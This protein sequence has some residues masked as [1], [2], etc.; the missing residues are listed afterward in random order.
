[1]PGYLDIDAVVAAAQRARR[2]RQSTPA[3]ASCPSGPGSPAAVEAA[4]LVLVGPSADG[5][6]RRWVARTR[7]ARSRSP[8]GF[9][10]CLT[11]TTTRRFPVLVKAAAGGGGKGMRIVRRAEEYA[12]AVAAAKREAKAAFGDDTMLVEKY[13]EHGRHIEVQVLGR[14][15][16]ERGAPLRAG[17]LHPAAAPEGARG[18]AGADHQRRAPRG[19]HRRGGRPGRARRLHQRRHRRVPARHEPAPARRLLPGDEHPAPGRAPGDRARRPG[20]GRALDLVELQLRVAAGEPLP[21][22]Q[23]DVTRRRARDRGPGL[24]RGPVRRLPPAGRARRPRAL[25][26]A[27]HAWTTRW[28]AGRRSA[29]PTTRCSARSSPTGPT[30]RPRAGRWS[31]PSTTPRSWV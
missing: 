16:R 30:A 7:P 20:P 10:S 5:D 28:R 9:P 1:M 18:G 4:G 8:Q 12:D 17:L 29:R 23:D 31:P 13:V 25:A 3:T 22:D 27:A 2:R 26:G 6:G 19:R 14:R 11:A 24:R 15:P 21:F